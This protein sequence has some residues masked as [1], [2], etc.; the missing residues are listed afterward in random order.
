[1]ANFYEHIIPDISNWPIYK[2][3]KDRENFVSRLNDFTYERI[4]SL[5]EGNLS[6]LIEKTIYLEKLRS[7]NTP[8]KVDPADEVSYWRGL[9]NEFRVILEKDDNEK[10]IHT[11][12]KRIINRYSEEITGSFSIKTFKF[13]RKF[14]TSFFKRLLNTAAGRNHRRIWGNKHQLRD[15]IQVTGFVEEFR[16]LFSKGTVVVVPTHFSNL[17]SIMIGYS[18]DA[19]VGVPA[20]AYGAGL[21]LYEMELFAFFMNRLGAYKVDRRKKNPIYLECL[22]SMACYSLQEGVNNIFFPGG[23]RSRNGSIEDKLKLGLLGSAVESQ[24]IFIQKEKPDKIFV[25][26]LILGYNFVLEAKY[27]IN[28]FLKTTGRE[29]YIKSKDQYNSYR[30]ILKFLWSLFSEKSEITL[31]FGEPMD[32]LGNKVNAEGTSLDKEGNSIDLTD[33]FKWEGNINIDTQRETVYTKMLGDAIL[34]SYYR[35]NVVLASHL[36][37]FA[38]FRVLMIENPKMSIFDIVNIPLSEIN[39]SHSKFEFVVEQ[40]RESLLIWENEGKINLKDELKGSIAE[41]IKTGIQN[42]G[43]YHPAKPLLYTQEGIESGD[44]RLLYFYHNRLENYK[45]DQFIDLSV[46]NSKEPNSNKG[47]FTNT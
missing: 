15:R 33:Y 11:L 8:W 30:K 18:M 3:S 10:E 16:H 28:S 20:F 25:V 21:N 40:L 1:L 29:K 4:L 27:L 26:P 34:D 39:I 46:Y 9:D 31:S 6:Q 42:L 23:T 5:H 32:V 43:P 22:K 24:R 17:D 44:L 12:L 13:I 38:A 2:I 41:V 37:A 45:L 36:V 7:K 35:N 47:S 14:L 19:V